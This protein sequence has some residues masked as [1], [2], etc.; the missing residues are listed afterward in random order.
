ML[1]E[2]QSVARIGSW[3]FDLAT[4]QVDWSRQIYALFGREDALGPPDFP[5]AMRYYAEEDTFA[6]QEAVAHT[7]ATGESYVLVLRT[8]RGHDGV[9]FLRGIGQARLDA[10]GAV[11]GMFGTVADVTAEIEREAALHRAQRDAEAAG[12]QLQE[13]NSFLEGET[14]RANDMAARAEL[15]SQTKSEFLA[16]VSHEIRTPLTA[17]LG[18]TDLLAEEVVVDEVSI[19]RA[20]TLQTIRRAGEHLLTV[21]NDVLDLSKI[22]SGKLLVERVDTDLPRIMLD[23]DSLMRPRAAA[24]GVEL[25]SAL[26]SSIPNRIWSDPTRL[27]QILPHP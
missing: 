12:Q 9:R 5:T 15:A 1:E 16:N 18:Y 19:R 25:Y 27:R 4:G 2:A 26:T 21:I 14:V 3:S 7:A 22:E 24:K 20:A 13:T 10:A 8:S 6:L 23:V 17:I 11:T